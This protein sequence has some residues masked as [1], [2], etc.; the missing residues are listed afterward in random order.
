MSLN[1]NQIITDI[2]ESSCREYAD[3]P[4]FTCMKHTLTYRELDRY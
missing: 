1:Y 4:A 3:S 2:F